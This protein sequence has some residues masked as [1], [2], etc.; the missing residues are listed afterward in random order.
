MCSYHVLIYLTIILNLLLHT[1]PLPSGIVSYPTQLDCC[2][3][4]FAGQSSNACVQSLPNPPTS[5]PTG[6]LDKYYVSSWG[7]PSSTCSNARPLPYEGIHLFDTKEECC[8]QSSSTADAAD[9]VSN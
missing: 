2:E 1:G 7:W 6:E 5:S 3:G 8:A 9:C 4:A